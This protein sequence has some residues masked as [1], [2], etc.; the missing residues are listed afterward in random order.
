MVR[1]KSRRPGVINS[2]RR[3]MY[4]YRIIHILVVSFTVV[5]LAA[6]GKDDILRTYGGIFYGVPNSLCREP[7]TESLIRAQKLPVILEK[8]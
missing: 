6:L 1:S 8:S 7:T 3:A 4:N 5:V 2:I